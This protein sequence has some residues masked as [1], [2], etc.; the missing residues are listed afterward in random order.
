MHIDG[1]RVGVKVSR[2]TSWINEG[3]GD[4]EGIGGW[5]NTLHLPFIFA[6]RYFYVRQ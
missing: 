3:G 4:R 1:L 2:K 6:Q 5:G